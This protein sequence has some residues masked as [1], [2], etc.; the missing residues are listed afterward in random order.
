MHFSIICNTTSLSRVIQAKETGDL[1][2]N[3]V[4]NRITKAP[5]NSPQ[6]NSEAVIN[7]H[8]KE[9]P[10]EWHLSPEERQKT[11]DDL[12]LI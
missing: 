11:L 7:E 9:K 2:G 5:K 4:V 12:R 10:E 8:G 6:N 1:I 3:K